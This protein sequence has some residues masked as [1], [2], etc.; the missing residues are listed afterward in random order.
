[1]GFFN[2]FGGG[3]DPGDLSNY[4]RR[5]DFATDNFAGIVK[6][7][8][9]IKVELDGTISVDGDGSVIQLKYDGSKILLNDTQVGFLE[10]A[11]FCLTESYFTYL[12]YNN[13]FY[14]PFAVNENKIVFVNVFIDEQAGGTEV[15]VRKVEINN[16]DNIYFDAFTL[17]QTSNKILAVDKNST[18]SK[19]PSALAVYKA[20]RAN[21]DSEVTETSKNA[22]TS[23]AIYQ[24]V[25]DSIATNTSYF[26]GQFD[27]LNDLKSY[28]GTVSNNDYAFVV[29]T[30]ET[31]NI[32][33]VRYKYVDDGTTWEWKK[34]YTLAN[35]TFTIDQWNTINS[36]LTAQDKTNLTTLNER[37]EKVESTLTEEEFDDMYSKIFG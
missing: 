31:G 22:V 26:I 35:T 7:G 9:G 11:D 23:E 14:V 24:F 18:D 28:S 33:Y 29:E 13:N 21:I 8:R 2:P 36:G 16:L 30:D 20:I 6:I 19:Y 34:E 1:M 27:S 32:N 25:N 15:R 3:G 17:E 10:I 37:V 5:T 12:T 4:V